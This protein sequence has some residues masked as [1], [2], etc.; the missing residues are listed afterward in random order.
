MSQK[1][2]SRQLDKIEERLYIVEQTINQRILALYAQIESLSERDR[3]SQA[4]EFITLLIT[5][6]KL[7]LLA[8]AVMIPWN[9]I[10]D[11]WVKTSMFGFIV[12]SSKRYKKTFEKAMSKKEKEEEKPIETLSNEESELIYEEEEEENEQDV[13]ELEEK[14]LKE[15]KEIND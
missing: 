15:R 12:K 9:A 6:F 7:I 4:V 2:L 14:L 1:Y 11:F 5:A 13:N 10:R 3:F 8:S